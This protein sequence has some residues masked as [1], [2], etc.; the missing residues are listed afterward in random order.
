M[1]SLA[2]DMSVRQPSEGVSSHLD[3]LYEKYDG[4]DVDQT[5]VG[6]DPAE[7]EAVAGGG[8]VVEVRVHVEGSEGLLAVPGD[9]EWARPGGVVEGDRPLA[10]TA[11][12]LVGQQTGVDC[13]VETLRS[14]S[15]V[16]LQ[17]EETG[18]QAWALQAL[19]AATAGTET[20]A[21][22]AAWRDQLPSYSTAF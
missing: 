6:V 10:A 8:D 2:R 18:E 12:E 15:L 21:A 9:D 19:F 14:V 3:A 11:E 7:F 5:T 16:C 17:C 22:G 4:F 13:S 1:V 20:P